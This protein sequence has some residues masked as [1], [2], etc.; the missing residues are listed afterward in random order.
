MIAWQGRMQETPS[1]T[2]NVAA[3]RVV[4]FMVKGRVGSAAG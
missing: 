1:I 3:D 4:V 2:A